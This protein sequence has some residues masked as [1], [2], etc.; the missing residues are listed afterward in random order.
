MTSQVCQYY[1]TSEGGWSG[2][3][4]VSL[5]CPGHFD[6]SEIDASFSATHRVLIK[7]LN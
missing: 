5:E 1:L 2:G 3:V 4:R 6:V 7:E